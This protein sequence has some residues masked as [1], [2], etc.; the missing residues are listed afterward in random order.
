[1]PERVSA[2]GL[3]VRFEADR[4]F[5]ALVHERPFGVY[6]LPKGRVEP[7]ES[8]EQAARREIREEAGLTDL[9]LL[10]NLGARERLSYDRRCWV[11]TKYH[12]FAT[13]QTAGR[14]SDGAHDY[15]LAWYPISALPAMLWREQRELVERSRDYLSESPRLALPG[16]QGCPDP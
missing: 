1:V 14:P 3:V 4:V 11:V 9:R 2:G 8:S 16:S 15:E 10:G 13:E 12:L 5:V 6:I 7:G